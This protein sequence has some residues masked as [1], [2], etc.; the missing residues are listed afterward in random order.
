MSNPLFEYTF[1][2]EGTSSKLV[3]IKMCKENYNLLCSLIDQEENDN[4][5]HV[6]SDGTLDAGKNYTN[7]CWLIDCNGNRIS[8]YFGTDAIFNKE[9]Q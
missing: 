3:A 9:D 2:I 4:E 8:A 5:N 1:D 6:Y 7:I